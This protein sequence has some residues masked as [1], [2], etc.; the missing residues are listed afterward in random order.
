VTVPLAS[1]RLVALMNPNHRLAMRGGLRLQDVEND[2]QLLRVGSTIPSVEAVKRL[3]E[4][5]DSI[6]LLPSSCAEFELAR[7]SLVAVNMADAEPVEFLLVH[8]RE[9]HLSRAARALRLLLEG[10]GVRTLDAA[11]VSAGRSR[12]PPS[13]FD[14]SRVSRRASGS[15]ARERSGAI[16]TAA[17]MLDARSR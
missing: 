15:M 1:D 5:T 16:T 12:V 6:A 3:L 10:A 13:T 4:L 11:F 9:R 7:G 2:A 14:R 17:V 8:R